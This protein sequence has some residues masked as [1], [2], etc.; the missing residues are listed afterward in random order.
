MLH[1]TP[2]A[3]IPRLLSLSGEPV[4]STEAKALEP[5]IRGD[6]RETVRDYVDRDSQIEVAHP[7]GH[8][9]IQTTVDAYGHLLPHP[10]EHETVDHRDAVGTNGHTRQ[11]PP[12]AEGTRLR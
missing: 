3:P 4:L 6:E 10:D 5:A 9:S 11:G 12:A 1:G 7:L 2:L 8:A